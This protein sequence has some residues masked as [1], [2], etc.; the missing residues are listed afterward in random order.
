MTAARDKEREH[1]VNPT[2]ETTGRLY[3]VATMT[4]EKGLVAL[5]YPD[6]QNLLAHGIMDEEVSVRMRKASFGSE[7]EQGAPDLRAQ[8]GLY[9]ITIEGTNAKPQIELGEAAVAQ[10][11]ARGLRD[12]DEVRLAI[13]PLPCR[14]PR[15]ASYDGLKLDLDL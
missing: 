5:D 11:R 4:G 2:Y 14:N 13:E 1:A 12:G 10:A 15:A 6:Y 8:A 3:V 9:T 7:Y